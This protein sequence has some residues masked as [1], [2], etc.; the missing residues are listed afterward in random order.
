M[1]KRLYRKCSTDLVDR[2]NEIL[3]RE[4]ALGDKITLDL[5]FEY[6]LPL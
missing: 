3:Y 6:F 2:I 5:I 1:P 4:A